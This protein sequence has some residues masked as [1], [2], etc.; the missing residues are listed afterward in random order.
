MIKN[1]DIC[2]F[3]KIDL[4]TLT[5]DDKIYSICKNIVI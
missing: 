1:K 2:L 5:Y 4:E 3:Q